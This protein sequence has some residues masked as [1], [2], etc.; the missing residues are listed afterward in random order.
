MDHYFRRPDG[1]V[2]RRS[3][4]V[5]DGEI[6]ERPPPA[7][8]GAVEISAEE[9]IAAFAAAAEGVEQ[10]RSADR[11][12]ANEARCGVYD[13]AIDLGFSEAAASAISGY[14]PA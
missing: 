14:R 13:E 2:V 9:G 1:Q 5:A 7:P 4:A 11:A 8:A 3:R 12:A 10:V 6:S